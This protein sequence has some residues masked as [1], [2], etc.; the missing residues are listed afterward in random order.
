MALTNF[1]KES[2]ERSDGANWTKSLLIEKSGFHLDSIEGCNQNAQNLVTH[3]MERA[4]VDYFEG[5]N[6]SLEEVVNQ[7]IELEGS[8]SLSRK[9]NF[10]KC[11]GLPLHYVLYSDED[12]RVYVLALQSLS[13]FELVKTYKSYQLFA[14]WIASVKGWKSAKAFREIKDLPYFDQALRAAGTPWPTNID[15]FLSDQNN[16][17]VGVLEFQN[18]KNT[19]VAA[20][21][22][23]DFFLCKLK[24]TSNDGKEVYHDD[25]RRWTSQEIIRVQSGLRFFILTWAPFEDNVMLKELEK[26]AIPYFEQSGQNIKWSHMRAY[27][28]DMHLYVS[29][30]RSEQNRLKLQEI[31]K[32]CELSYKAGVMNVNVS[33]GPLSIEQKSFPSLYY[34][35]KALCID[36]KNNLIS[37]FKKLVNVPN[38]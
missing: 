18:A 38:S 25:I 29:S 6:A 22:N 24:T 31:Y 3:L 4:R 19:K 23:N 30:N 12:E 1:R 9:I 32:T 16:V 37:N 20:H 7:I 21:C 14:D 33:K 8:G 28:R 15:C 36:G 2:S 17:P 34:Q 11:F 10:A 5:A 35:R 13:Q 26:I 27:K